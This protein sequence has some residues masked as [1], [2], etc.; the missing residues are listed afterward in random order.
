V[1][2]GELAR[3]TGVSQRLLRYYEQQD[4]IRPQRQASGYRE[5]DEDDVVTVQHIRSLLAAGLSTVTIAEVLPCMAYQGSR[6]RVDC[7]ELLIDLLRERARINASI[8]ELETARGVLDEVIS[9]A[10]TEV[11]REVADFQLS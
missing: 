6:L 2:I 7:A 4:L 3:R 8:S 1:K 5:Y 9:T 11:R 10:P